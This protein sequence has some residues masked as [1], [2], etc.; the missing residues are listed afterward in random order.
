M[1]G[2]A[3]RGGRYPRSAQWCPYAPFGDFGVYIFVLSIPAATPS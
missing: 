2:K 3:I 1:D